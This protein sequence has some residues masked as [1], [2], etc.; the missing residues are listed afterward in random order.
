M[1][2]IK[3]TAITLVAFVLL[4]CGTTQQPLPLP[5]DFHNNKTKVIGVYYDELPEVD[6]YEVG[7]GCLLC[8]ATVQIA[9]ASLTKH[10]ETLDHTEIADLGNKITSYISEKGHEAKLIDSK[11]EISKLKK[12][13]TK[14]LNFA[15]KDFRPLKNKLNVDSLLVI[16]LNV[17]GTFRTYSGYVPTS[18]P[19]GAVKGLIYLV[20]LNTNQYKLYKNLDIQV[21]A[22]G[23]WDEPPT[24]P[25]VT[26]AY[27]K[28]LELS[29]QAV[30]STLL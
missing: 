9:N 29:K 27:F 4:A 10:I 13:K 19:K 16:D 1:K 11:I 8:I 17:V 30:K 12:F 5:N 18:D 21:S 25:G 23:E 6:T 22:E 20:D 24:F 15:P 28:A 7:A 26:N 3:I 2:I 14:E